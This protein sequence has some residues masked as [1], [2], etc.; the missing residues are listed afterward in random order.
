MES[1]RNV[2]KNVYIYYCRFWKNSLTD[3]LHLASSQMTGQ[4]PFY[5]LFIK[6]E[7]ERSVEIIG[8]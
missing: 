3:S 1:F 8:E 7:I 5:Y 4:S 2:L 6:R